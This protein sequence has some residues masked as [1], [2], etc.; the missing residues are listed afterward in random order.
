M[1]LSEKIFLAL[2]KRWVLDVREASLLREGKID[3]IMLSDKSV[4]MDGNTPIGT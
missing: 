3:S 2:N 4:T 1:A